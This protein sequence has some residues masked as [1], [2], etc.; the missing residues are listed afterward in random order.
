MTII[1]YVCSLGPRCHTAS[2]LK[3]NHLKKASYP[4]DWI[5]SDIDMITHCLEDD[6]N[7]FLD[8]QYFTILDKKSKL[9]I[10]STQ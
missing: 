10:F 3:R 7:I 5:F 2:F 9:D 6:F 4:F 8:K 1:K